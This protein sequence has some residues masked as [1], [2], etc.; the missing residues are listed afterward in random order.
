MRDG[1]GRARSA[2][3][4]RRRP[5]RTH[6]ARPARAR[7]ISVAASRVRRIDEDEV[8][9][10]GGSAP[11]GSSS[12]ARTSRRDDRGRVARP[13]PGAGSR[14]ST[15][16]AAASRST[17]TA[18]RRRPATGPRSRRHH[19]PR[20]GRARR[21]R[22]RRG[23]R[24]AEQR[25]LDPVGQRARARAGRRQ[26]DAPSG[27]GDHP[28][29]VRQRRPDRPQPGRSGRARRITGED[30]AQP[31]ALELAGQGRPV[32][33]QAALVVERASP[34]MSRA[35]ARELAVSGLGERRHP[36]PGQAALGEPEDVALAAEL[37]VPLRQL[38]PVAWSRQRPAAAPARSSVRAR[39]SPARRTTRP[40][41]VPR[42]PGAGGAGRARTA[43]RPR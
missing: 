40:F 39:R 1:G 20:T 42:G 25:L 38:E 30:P 22:S 15:A 4:R 9:A 18:D 11:A 8:E 6:V 34:R 36:Q 35:R 17:N 33:G 43:R 12:H 28:P 31:A 14:R 37:E 3:P 27:A 7:A 13:A 19:C 23:S 10:P 16:A 24:I 21:H 5:P 2:W 26:P 41:P 29:R 32:G